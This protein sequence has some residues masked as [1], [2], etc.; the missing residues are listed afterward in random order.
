MA[1]EN[2]SAEDDKPFEPSQ[3]RLDEARKKGDIPRSVDLTSAAAQAGLL[4]FLFAAGAPMLLRAGEV[5]ALPLRNAAH[6]A[7]DIANGT[8]QAM[9][10][11]VFGPLHAILAPIFLAP[12]AAAIL[13][14][15]AQRAFVI[16]PDRLAPKLDRISPLAALK[17]KYGRTGLFEFGKSF[18]K[19]TVISLVLGVFIMLKAGEM[20]SAMYLPALGA[21][22]LL[23]RILA[24]F[25]VLTFIINAVIGGLDFGWQRMEFL[26]KHRMS[27]KELQDEGKESEGDPHT[28]ARRRE[29]A[30][31]IARNRMLADVPDASVVIV[32]PTHVAVALSWSRAP[33]SAPICVA[34]GEDQVALRI[35]EIAAEAGVPIH[36]DPATARALFRM[37]DIG[38]VIAPEHYRAVAVAIRFADRVRGKRRGRNR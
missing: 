36:R 25:L 33:G 28:K 16:A 3:K 32:N 37:T 8:G 30:V 9:A 20:L 23:V 19:L 38:A 2:Q 14:I 6:L 12:A 17:N 34:K 7:E 31:A 35:R 26:R 4:L 29:R 5:L 24:E 15:V 27:R 13:G 1:D 10:L 21:T 18:V 11:G 22:G